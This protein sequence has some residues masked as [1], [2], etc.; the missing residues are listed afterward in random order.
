WMHFVC[1]GLLR[2]FPAVPT[3]S[4]DEAAYEVQSDSARGVWDWRAAY[5]AGHFQ[6]S[7]EQCAARSAA[8]GGVDDGKR[9]VGARLHVFRPKAAARAEPAAQD[10]ISGG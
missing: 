2:Y 9:Q 6:L 3:R 7:A 8:G 10:Q 4:D 5:F 1:A